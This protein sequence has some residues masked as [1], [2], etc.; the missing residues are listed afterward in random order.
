MRSRKRPLPLLVIGIIS[1]LT[2]ASLIYFFSPVTNLTL[3]ETFIQLPFFLGNYIQIS[4]LPVFFVLLAIFL[5][6][7]GSYIFNSK[8]HGILIAGFVIIYLLFRLTHL[9][10]PFFLILLLALFFSLEMFVSSRGNSKP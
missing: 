2:L 4:P 10:H 8:T 6:S 9:T 5:F 7:I 1:L 3:P